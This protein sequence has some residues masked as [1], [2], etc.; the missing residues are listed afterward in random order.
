M[1]EL[2]GGSG[3]C[4][5]TLEPE[6]R[7]LVI[8]DG[9]L[10][11][12]RGHH[13]D[14]STTISSA[15]LQRGGQVI[16][17]T[18]RSFAAGLAPHGVTIE[19]FF[20]RSAYEL[21]RNGA[22]D[23]DLS[24]EYR[25]AFQAIANDWKT[26]NA[27]VLCHT[28]DAHVYRALT[29]GDMPVRSGAH[30]GPSFHI[31]TPYPAKLMLGARAGV[32]PQQCLEM[33][34][35]SPQLGRG[36]YLWAETGRLARHFRRAYGLPVDAL[37]LPAPHWSSATAVPSAQPTLQVV[38][39]GAAR[40]DKGFLLLPPLIEAVMADP[41]LREKVRFTVQASA[42]QRG[43]RPRLQD[44]IGRLN[45]LAGVTL[46]EGHLGRDEYRA[47]LQASDVVL[48]LYEP[49]SY[50]L[51][52]S[53]IAIEALS[54]GKCI[55][56]RSGL[57][58]EDIVSRRTAALGTDNAA[59]LRALRR[60]ARNLARTRRLAQEAGAAFRHARRPE[61]YLQTMEWRERNAAVETALPRWRAVLPIL[62]R[63]RM[64][65]R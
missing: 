41:E 46:V 17:Y 57:F 37:P 43:Y 27:R 4:A 13:L 26:R 28:A 29:A 3:A 25:A 32:A 38:Y 61:L 49:R 60:W 7:P 1:R 65:A 14:L 33:L 50:A 19:P 35:R 9:C 51:R 2:T 56:G 53:A 12:D 52:G 62:R 45:A 16:W 20:V 63:W 31:A 15:A 21:M 36:L 58:L 30:S 40:E 24:E 47:V 18:H 55:L 39:L 54:C 48:V 34:Q 42:P 23:V 8:V 10:E 11:G 64:G 22:D 6:A 44:A 59:W 5:M